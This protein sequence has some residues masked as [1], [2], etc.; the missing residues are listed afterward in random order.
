[1]ST[2]FLPGYHSPRLA[3]LMSRD[4]G[5][6]RTVVSCRLAVDARGFGDSRSGAGGPSSKPWSGSATARGL[7]SAARTRALRAMNA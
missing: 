2:Q 4:H 5:G 3:R 6:L 7:I 1:M